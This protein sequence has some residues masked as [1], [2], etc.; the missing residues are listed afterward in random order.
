MVLGKDCHR[1]RHAV[2]CQ[3]GRGEGRDP[4]VVDGGR[5]RRRVRLERSE[6]V[7]GAVE[8]GMCA[9][10]CQGSLRL[11]FCVSWR[12][13]TEVRGPYWLLREG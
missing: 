4:R 8:D 1:P 2:L 9:D 6:R 7:G 3:R 10:D 12:V 5:R 11:S 13:L